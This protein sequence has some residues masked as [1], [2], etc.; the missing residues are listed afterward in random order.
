MR[1]VSEIEAVSAAEK[2]TN[3]GSFPCYTIGRLRDL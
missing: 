2:I 3:N 1:V